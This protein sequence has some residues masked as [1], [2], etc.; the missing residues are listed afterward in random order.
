MN[1]FGFGYLLGMALG[2]A[3]VLISLWIG[4]K[5]EDKK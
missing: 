1:T 3:T 2:I 5:L 4:R